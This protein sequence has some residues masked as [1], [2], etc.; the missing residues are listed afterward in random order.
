MNMMSVETFEKAL[1]IMFDA[2]LAV[3]RAEAQKLEEIVAREGF[4]IL[5]KERKNA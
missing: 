4:V 5:D 2:I 1:A 3:A